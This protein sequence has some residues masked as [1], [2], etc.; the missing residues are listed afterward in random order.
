MSE[1]K[2]PSLRFT[3]HDRARPYSLMAE[4]TAEI[5]MTKEEV[6]SIIDDCLMALWMDKEEQERKESKERIA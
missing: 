2:G 4:G 1:G 5:H 3:Q 6:Q